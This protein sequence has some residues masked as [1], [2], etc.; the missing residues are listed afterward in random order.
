[1]ILA[2]GSSSWNEVLTGWGVIFALI[3]VG[4]V[5]KKISAAIEERRRRRT[6]CVHGV[7]GAAYDAALCA[8]C[9]AEQTRRAAIWAQEEKERKRAEEVERLKKYNEWAAKIR[10]PEYVKSMDPRE[11]QV[12]VCRLFQQMGFRVE[13]TPYVGDN[14]SD[15]Y[16]FKNG[17][18]TVLQCKR[19]KAAVGEPVLRDLFGTMHANQCANAIVVTTGTPSKQARV[20][21]EGKPIRIIELEELESLLRH[22]F[23]ESTIIPESFSPNGLSTVPCPRCG[24]QLRLVN[25]RHGSFI[26]C[27]GYPDCRYTAE[28][29]ANGLPAPRRRF[30]MRRS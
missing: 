15:G 17:E 14:G 30:R 26:G 6:P 16:L 23:Q 3:A 18:K 5:S 12:L 19:V 1:M 21:A 4:A 8:A 24:K 22:H 20:W 27:T 10:L 2:Y 28:P 13:Q 11:F 9:T 29:D 7:H 25:G